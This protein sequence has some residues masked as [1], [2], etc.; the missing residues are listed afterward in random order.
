MGDTGSTF[1]GNGP[2]G[3]SA[4]HVGV[5]A[6]GVVSLV[7]ESADRTAAA[8]G[9]YVGVQPSSNVATVKTQAKD[10][11]ILNPDGTPYGSAN[12]TAYAYRDPVGN[13]YGVV[14][15]DASTAPTAPSYATWAAHTPSTGNG[16]VAVFSGGAA[17]S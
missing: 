14:N 17:P 1:T 5:D 6:N 2:S 3:T 10:I 8:Y 9:M 7:A 12:P 16:Y 4:M 13:D 15:L 11:S